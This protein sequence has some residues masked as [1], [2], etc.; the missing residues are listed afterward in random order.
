MKNG[1]SENIRALRKER[2]L[3][4][5]QLAEAMG[6]T[7]GAVYKWEQELSTPDI[8][9][10]MDLASFFGVSVDALV[11]YEMCSSDR[12]RI[13]QTLSRIKLEK[14]YKNCWDEVEAGLRRYPN[15]FDVVYNSGVLYSLASI[16]TNNKAQQARSAQLLKHACS[17]IG[18]NRDPLISETSIYRDIAISSL[19]IGHEEEGL[20]LLKAHNPCGIHDDII[21]QEL[22]TDPRRREDAL[23]YLSDALL[24]C[25][26]RLCRVVV[27]FINVFFAREDYTSALDMLHWMIAYLDGLR[28]ESGTNCLDKNSVW[29]LALCAAVHEKTGGREA[30]RSCL[31]KARD[32][33]LKF[34][35][36]P[37][38]TNRNIRYCER[39]RPRASYDNIGGS[40]MDTVLNVL[41]EGVE[42]PDEPILA[43]WEEICNE[44]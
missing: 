29:L 28:A 5:E 22:A 14:D 12:E 17:L 37:D 3:T 16:E 7:A 44:T 42:G 15:D 40:A 30:A 35:A 19:T 21:G 13:L 41:K 18:Q 36:A 27:G 31:R 1:F 4:Q 26:V 11:G 8:G 9:V 34:D 10:I 24:N 39:Q 43:L 33:A 6:V 2:H 20:E 25:T 23:P 38:Y 32:I